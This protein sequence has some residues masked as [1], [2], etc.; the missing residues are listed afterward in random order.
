[1]PEMKASKSKVETVVELAF[2]ALGLMEKGRSVVFEGG[3]K[4]P[5]MK[6]L[7]SKV[8]EVADA[9]ADEAVVVLVVGLKTPDRKPLKSK[10]DVVADAVVA[11]VVV[12]FGLGLKK[13]PKSNGVLVAVSKTQFMKLELD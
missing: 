3:L 12:G 2:G 9:L 10:A 1:M 4:T 11:V 6:A 5:E 7:K 8:D 13:P